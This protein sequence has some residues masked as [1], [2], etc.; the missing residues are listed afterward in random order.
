MYVGDLY[1]GSMYYNYF[2][3]ICTMV[4]RREVGSAIRFTEGS[5]TYEEWECLGHIARCGPAAFLDTI[6]ALQHVHAGPRITDAD[7]VARA[8][9]RLRVL[10]NVWGSDRAFLSTHGDEYDA[11]VYQIRLAKVRALIVLGRP[12]DARREMRELARV[13]LAYRV[14]SRVPAQCMQ[15]LVSLR[16]A[17]SGS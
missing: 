10:A 12:R 14:A 1:R 6:G 3:I 4:R 2:S 15:A 8:E 16:H 9:S 7:W 11:L 17:W 13:P 5:S